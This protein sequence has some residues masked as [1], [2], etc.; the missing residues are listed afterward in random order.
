MICAA[1]RDVKLGML[2]VRRWNM[3]LNWDLL[4]HNGYVYVIDLMTKLGSGHQGSH[5]LML[6][7]GASVKI[8]RVDRVTI[9]STVS[10]ISTT[11]C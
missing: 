6:L 3:R 4:R 8:T 11:L 9:Q 5:I 7:I 10:V 1:F 2:N